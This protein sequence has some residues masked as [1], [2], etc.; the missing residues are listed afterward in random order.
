MLFYYSHAHTLS[1]S[2]TDQTRALAKGYVFVT[3]VAFVF[4]FHQPSMFPAT[5]GPESS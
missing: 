1:R 5:P 4:A 2:R 3:L